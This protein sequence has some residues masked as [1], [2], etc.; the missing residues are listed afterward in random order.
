MS[1]KKTWLGLFLASLFISINWLTYIY[2]VNTNHIVEASLGYY[3]N[4]LIA[5]LLGVFVL[6][7]KVNILQASLICYSWNRCYLYDDIGWKAPVDFAHI[8]LILRFLW[9]V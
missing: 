1:Q 8:S 5:V 4:P 2:A 6:R 3:I 9:I 7:E